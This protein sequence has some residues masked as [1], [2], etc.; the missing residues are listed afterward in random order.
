[1]KTITK[2]A[3]IGGLLASNVI[4]AGPNPD[5][6]SKKAACSHGAHSKMKGQG[7]EGKGNFLERMTDRL[8]LTPEQRGSIEAALQQSKPQITGIK[9]KMQA[10][11]KAL[12][13][14]GREGKSDA[15]HV[16][17][18]AQERGYLVTELVIQRTKI[19]DEIRQVLTDPQR[20]QM[21]QMREKK[22]QHHSKA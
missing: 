11:R 6:D 20:E 22:H 16:Q 14:L 19:R 17:T 3:L 12:R 4:L 5:T 9:E 1:M 7:M 2:I 18:L 13:E 10:N 21:K 15:D 8:K